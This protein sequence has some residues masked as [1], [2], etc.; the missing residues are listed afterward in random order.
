VQMN[1]IGRTH[2]VGEIRMSSMFA[3]YAHYAVPTVRAERT[4]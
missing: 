1:I 4:L 2:R 3:S